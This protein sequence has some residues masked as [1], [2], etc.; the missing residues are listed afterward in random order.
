MWNEFKGVIVNESKDV[1]GVTLISK[2]GLHG[3]QVIDLL[4][5]K[6]K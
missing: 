4:L 6:F 2:K 5:Y 3:G 1:C